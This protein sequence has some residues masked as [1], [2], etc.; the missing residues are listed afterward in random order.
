MPTVKCYVCGKEKNIVPAKYK[1]VMSSTG[2]FFCSRKHYWI[3]RN[4]DDGK[5]H[6]SAVMRALAAKGNLVS[7]HAA[8]RGKKT[9]N[10]GLTAEN[11]CRM[12]AAR[13]N[14]IKY[15]GGTRG[16]SRAGRMSIIKSRRGFYS[17]VPRERLPRRQKIVLEVVERIINEKVAYEYF[18][19]IDDDVPIFVDV[20]VPSLKLAIEVDGK[21]HRLKSMIEKD[22]IRDE[23]LVAMGWRIVRITNDVVDNDLDA[24]ER[25]IRKY[26]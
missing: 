17:H 12:K 11:D 23:A 8:T 10:A 16:L 7:A 1:K 15:Y 19:L 20:A 21:E 3:W 2:K 9:W 24:V 14:R 5:E 22:K 18:M 13:K 6:F 4:S 26:S 25:A